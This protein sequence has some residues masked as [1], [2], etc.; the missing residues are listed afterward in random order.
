[1]KNH[2][3]LPLIYAYRIIHFYPI[4]KFREAISLKPRLTFENDLHHQLI[5]EPKFF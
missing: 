1:M 2:S 4:L 3:H 5:K